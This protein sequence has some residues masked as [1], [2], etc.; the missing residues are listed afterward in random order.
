MSH[1]PR[2]VVI[3]SAGL[4]VVVLAGL[5]W[6]LLKGKSGS[7]SVQVTPTPVPVPVNTLDV[8]K[9]PF[10]VL[11]PLPGRNELAI[12]IGKLAIPAK[13][14]EVTLEYD[15][16]KGVLDAVLKQFPLTGDTL[17]ETV[18][19]GSKS[20][21]G[22]TT[23]HEDV[24][25]GSLT[26]AFIGT[27]PYT[28]KVPWHYA[29]TQ[30]EYSE[31]STTDGFFQAVLDKPIKQSKIIV[32]QSPG[33]PAGFP[34]ELIAGPYLI[35]TVGDLPK[36]NAQVS[37]RLAQDSP[38]AVLYGWDGNAWIKLTAAIEGKT[39]IYNGPLYSVFAV[40]R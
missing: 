14:V 23:Y 30:K 26:L 11:Q 18:F 29:D 13:T 2:L 31:L 40:S 16:N 32:M 17:N 22:H 19:L 36:V 12:T 27:E 25:G 9:R 34:G 39:V 24:I 6:Y 3:I 28:L 33:P 10:V 20:A 21:G 5:G 37:I 15:R 1:S 4:A 35:R 7:S 38:N 8:S